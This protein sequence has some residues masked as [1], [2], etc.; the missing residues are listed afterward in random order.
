M[1]C[2][3][4]LLAIAIAIAVA[5]PVAARAGTPSQDLAWLNEKR[6]ANGI[7]GGIVE[8][9]EWSQACRLHLRYLR[10]TGTISH[11]EDRGS[12][13]FTEAGN[14][15]GTHA[16]LASTTPWTREN[17]IWELSLIHI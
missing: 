2:T 3:P 15:A 13:W 6:E 14:W 7:P 10:E 9:P 11:A 16:V 8:V 17:F 4:A 12:R 1:R 5:M